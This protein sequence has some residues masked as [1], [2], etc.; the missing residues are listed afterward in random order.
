MDN[1]VGSKFIISVL[2][3]T[4]TKNKKKESHFL[5]LLPLSLRLIETL[6]K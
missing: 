2:V 1:Y 5:T 6:K 3:S 4:S